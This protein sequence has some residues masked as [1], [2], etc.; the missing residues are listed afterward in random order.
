MILTLFAGIRN[1]N[2]TYPEFMVELMR[3]RHD[4][5]GVVDVNHLTLEDIRRAVSKARLLVLD[6]SL[7][8]AAI[9]QADA[10]RGLRGA[11]VLDGMESSFYREAIEVVLAASQPKVFVASGWD[12]HWRADYFDQLKGK[13]QALA[14]MFDKPPMAFSAVPERYRDLWMDLDSGISCTEFR[15]TDPVAVWNEM[16]ECFP[17]HI[18][19]T[20][21]VTEGEFFLG[22]AKRFWQVSVPGVSYATRVV[23][24]AS[25]HAAGHRIGPFERRD[26]LITRAAM[27]AES[28]FGST[29]ASRWWIAARGW[30]QRAL[31]RD[32]QIGCTCGS[33]VMYT[34]RKF[35]EIPAAGCALV[36]YADPHLV[37]LGFVN[38]KN[39]VYSSPED[40]GREV[41]RLLSRPNELEM[42]RRAGFEMVRAL[43][44][45]EKRVSDFVECL[46]R[47]GRGRLSHASFVS[48]R[49]EIR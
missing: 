18:E 44:S 35:F 24:L 19:L 11:V 41:A 10:G 42:I 14:W 30:N 43:H 37:N 40:Y 22:G 48:G 13:V 25:L 36:C 17:I 4:A 47:M 33:G 6:N 45:M 3:H 34:V 23:G 12:L 5:F 15:L 28:L 26:A 21:A 38:G 29:H 1:I 7:Y 31:L 27:R 2:V 49:Y 20:H 39:C 9:N 32:S 16:A 46:R 8:M